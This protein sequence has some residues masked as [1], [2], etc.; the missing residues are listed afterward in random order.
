MWVASKLGVGFAVGGEEKVGSC[1]NGA[2]GAG[3]GGGDKGEGAHWG[4]KGDDSTGG[5]DVRSE[6]HSG[7]PR[8]V[9]E[10][11]VMILRRPGLLDGV[12]GGVEK[13]FTSHTRS[14]FWGAHTIP[15]C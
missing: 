1:G 9:A 14:V 11:G 15:G 8:V 3:G 6:R 12:G 7:S 10:R 2:V 13:R 4:R 5:G